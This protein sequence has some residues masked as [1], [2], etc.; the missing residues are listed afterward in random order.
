MPDRAGGPVLVL[1][2]L[3]VRYGASFAEA[4]TL[5]DWDMHTLV[6]SIDKITGQWCGARI[7]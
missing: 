5:L 6:D 4:V 3:N 7:H 2:R 1:P